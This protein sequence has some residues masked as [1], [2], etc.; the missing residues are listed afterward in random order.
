MTD[1]TTET[2]AS[3]NP[4]A[5]PAEQFHWLVSG[6]IWHPKAPN[7]FAGTSEISQRGQVVTITAEMLGASGWLTKYLGDDDAQL[8]KWGEVRIRPGAWPSG[9]PTWTPGTPEHAEAREAARRAAHAQ[10]T[11]EA[12]DAA[13]REVQ[14][15]YGGMPTTSR[16]LNASTTSPEQ[17]AAEEQRRRMDA[18]GPRQTTR[19]S[20]SERGV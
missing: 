15:I 2:T 12:R 18:A 11:A 1:T 4:Y 6:V 9:E 5:R 16:T 14:A 19:Y 10:P 3:E 8:R 7:M 13:L 20:P 17:R